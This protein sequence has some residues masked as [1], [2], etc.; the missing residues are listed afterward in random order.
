MKEGEIQYRL[1]HRTQPLFTEAAGLTLLE[2]RNRIYQMGYIGP[3]ADGVYA[4][5]LSIR[6]N[7]DDK[8]SGSSSLTAGQAN[9]P[10][11]CFLITGN[12][13]GRERQLSYRGLARIDSYDPESFAL[14]SS[15]EVHP[16]SESLTHAV[17]YELSVEIGLIIHLHSLEMWQWMLDSGYPTTYAPYGS[18][19]LVS[20]IK[21]LYRGFESEQLFH[22][23]AFVMEGHREG[24]FL[25]ERNSGAAMTA[26]TRLL[27][28]AALKSP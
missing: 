13:S 23:N 8:L 22:N 11:V 17:L 16:S 5:N 6:L 28:K 3:G 9:R 21:A 4:G 14:R 15:G 19:A 26:L 20:E 24:V 2:L 25:F 10:G 12:G 1:D 18:A 27:A 7:P